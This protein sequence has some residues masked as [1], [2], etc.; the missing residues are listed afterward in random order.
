MKH[1]VRIASV[2]PRVHLGNVTKNCEEI[3]TVYRTYAEQVDVIVTPELSLTGY[4]CG[5]LFVNRRLIDRAE[6]GLLQLAEMTAE[7]GKKGAALVVGVPYE[8]DGEL[9]NCGAF[10]WNGTVLALTPKVYLPNYG[11]FYEKRW[12]SGR[13]VENRTVEMADGSET[14]FGNSILL[15]MTDPNQQEEHVT[16]GMEI[17]EDLWTPIAPGRLLALQGAEIL[18]NL[19]ASNEVIGKEQYR[20]TLTGSMSSSCICG[21]VYTSAGAYES[22]SDLVFSGHNLMYENGKLLGE[23][24]PFE[25]GILIRDFN[26]TKI[27]HDRL[28]N[29]SFAECKRNFDAGEYMTVTCEKVFAEKKE[30][31][32]RVSMTPFV[33]S[34][35]RL[36]R[37]R[38]I[39]AMQVA[40]L[41]P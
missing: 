5:D 7:Y 3:E 22:T 18:L 10:L 28:A 27:R 15:E 24:K 8:V 39:F 14:L 4:T 36:E 17:C 23:I 34:K 12:F 32:A 13:R 9:F 16:F 33:P 1:L 25:D 6:E 37:C 11:E 30:V 20:R 2:S 41:L 35:N 21:Y 29:K 26:M 38:S 31:C 19:S 40:G